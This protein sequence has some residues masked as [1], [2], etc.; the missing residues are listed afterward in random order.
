MYKQVLA[1]LDGS[2][3]TE[4]VFRHAEQLARMYGA[5]LHLCRAI[6]VPA[7]VPI[8]AWALSG[9][10]LTE[11]LTED[12]HSDLAALRG[13]LSPPLP[14]RDLVRVGRPAQVICD[15]ADELS[16]DLVVIGSHGF[17]VLDR[18]LGTTAGRVV[19][20]AHC[21]VMVVRPPRSA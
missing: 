7:G 21:S 1:A 16:C 8:E 19:N 9:V 18:L 10:E 13:R 17:D 20:H 5:A 6:N 3:R 14:G 11:K 15:L 12:A 2:P 4:L